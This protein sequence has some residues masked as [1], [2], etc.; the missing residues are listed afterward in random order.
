MK[1]H[2]EVTLKIN[3][4]MDASLSEDDIVIEVRGMLLDQLS[5]IQSADEFPDP[6]E[7]L[8]VREEAEIYGTKE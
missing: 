7:I 6:V 3:L 4:S 8:M 1:Q 5:K 2:V